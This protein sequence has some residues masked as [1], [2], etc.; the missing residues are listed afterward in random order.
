MEL[1]A[2]LDGILAAPPWAQAGMVL[3]LAVALAMVG[4][5]ILR[6]R[7]LRRQFAG[8]AKDLGV[9]TVNEPDEFT[10][11]FTTTVA[12][13]SFLVSHEFRSGGGR[14]SSYRGPT[15]H[16]LVT[17]T[18]LAAGQ[19]E[20]HQV[21]I[22][23]GRP[24]RWL[25]HAL[26]ETG[27]EVFDA[28]FAV[29]QDGVPVRDRWLDRPTRAAISAF[30]DTAGVTGPVWIQGQKVM[31]LAYAPWKGIEGRSLRVLLENQGRLADALERTASG[32]SV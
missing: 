6:K 26:L 15:G 2:A 5:P 7:R 22:V 29:K 9:P 1:R 21:D 16:L 31:H 12:G 3:F 13:R 18:A 24:P 17:S 23:P 20:L 8:L 4:L 11:S 27:D 10:Q 25:G 19:W 28:R 32:R 30:F 14:H